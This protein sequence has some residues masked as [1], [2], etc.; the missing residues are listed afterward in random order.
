MDHTFISNPKPPPFLQQASTLVQQAAVG[1]HALGLRKGDHLA[2]F[3][4]NSALWLLTE[5]GAARNGCPTAVR[6]AAAPLEELRYIYN[7]A[8]AKAVVLQVGSLVIQARGLRLPLSHLTCNAKKNQD[9]AL[10]RRL[11]AA[12]WLASAAHGRPRLVVLVCPP[13]GGA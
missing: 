5:Q 3:A 12:G 9:M 6:G 11:Q 10:L 2:L 7:H 4:E 1:L 8:D 13:E